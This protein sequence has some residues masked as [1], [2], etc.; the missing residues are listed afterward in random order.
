MDFM[1]FD[2]EKKRRRVEAG[3]R[4]RN[5]DTGNSS[6]FWNGVEGLTSGCK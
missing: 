2:E 4:R 1:E 5:G 3:T 6:F